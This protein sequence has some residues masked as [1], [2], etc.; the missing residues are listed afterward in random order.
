[1]LAETR[2]YKWTLALT[3]PSDPLT[4]LSLHSD[5]LT[6]SSCAVAH[7]QPEQLGLAW[8]SSQ[9]LLAGLLIPFPMM[10]RTSLPD[11]RQV[12]HPPSV[13]PH[14]DLRP[15][16]SLLFIICCHLSSDNCCAVA[17]TSAQT[18]ESEPVPPP[19]QQPEKQDLRVCRGPI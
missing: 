14:H 7:H 12:M 5:P 15:I 16:Q 3:A 9:A 19:I 1:M 8:M 4:L 2:A 18:K 6:L 10:P 17:D 13:D 11:Q